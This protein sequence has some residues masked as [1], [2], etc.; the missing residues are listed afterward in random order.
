MEREDF[1]RQL[2]RLR[3]TISDGTCFFWAS[4][5]L[6][7][8]DEA[9]ARGLNRYRAFFVPARGALLDMALLEFNAVFYE[10]HK[11][12]TFKY[13][14]REA[15]KNPQTLIPCATDETLPAIEGKLKANKDLLDDLLSYRNQRL[16]H[17]GRIVASHDSVTVE[18]V[19]DLMGE[20]HSMYNLLSV[21]HGNPRT[22][23]ERTA[24][25]VQ[26]HTSQ[27]VDLMRIQVED[28]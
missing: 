7:V 4:H 18:R 9:S 22:S 8:D 3:Q 1:K 15:R 20:V 16:A 19:L 24:G 14:L 12:V 2:D 6:M 23:F 28:R 13:L 17:L 26:A 10:H 25:E 11:A 27:L 21:A 5:G